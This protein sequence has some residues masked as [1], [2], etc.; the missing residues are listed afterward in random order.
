MRWGFGA[1]EGP[2]EAWQAAGWTQVA[3]WIREDIEAGKT[4]APAP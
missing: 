4:L 1:Q 3:Q 2:F